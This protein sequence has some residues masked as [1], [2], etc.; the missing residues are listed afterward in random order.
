MEQELAA[1]LGE[2]QIAEF[3]KDDE[4]HAGQAT[5]KPPLPRVAGLIFEPVDDIDHIAEPTASAG[6]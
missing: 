4:V 1:G 3:V 6:S 2:G 5:S